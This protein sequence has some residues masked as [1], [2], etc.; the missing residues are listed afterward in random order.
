MSRVIFKKNSNKNNILIILFFAAFIIIAADFGSEM[1]AEKDEI[2]TILGIFEET[3][4]EVVLPTDF[5]SDIERPLL[6]EIPLRD[7]SPLEF[8]ARFSVKDRGPPAV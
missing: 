2:G 7:S 3:D 1:A 4:T 5:L 8:I 6:F